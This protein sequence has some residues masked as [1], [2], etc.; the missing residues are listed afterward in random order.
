MGITFNA[1]PPIKFY[2]VRPGDSLKS[3]SEKHNVSE[4][5]IQADNPEVK[6]DVQV[7]QMLVLKTG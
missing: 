3:I 7:G 1:P 5:I 6:G 2:Q 4:D